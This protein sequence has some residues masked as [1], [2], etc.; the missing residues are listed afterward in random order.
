MRTKARRNRVNTFVDIVTRSTIGI[1][2]KP[3]PTSASIRPLIV[4]TLLRTASVVR[5]A[6]I[7][8]VA[9]FAISVESESRPAGAFEG[10][11]GVGANVGASSIASQALV[12][13][14]GEN[15]SHVL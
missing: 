5:F 4:M 11:G 15:F 7:D 6:F 13:V 1:Q 10:A 8:V 14:C 2:C 12:V 3:S 9:G